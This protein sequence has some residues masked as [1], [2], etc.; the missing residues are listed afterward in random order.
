MIPIKKLSNLSAKELNRLFNR[1][2]EDFASI[3]IEA[4]IP[5]VRDVGKNGEQAVIKYT[6]KFD[7]VDLD[8]VVASSEEIEAGRRNVPDRL[9]DAFLEAKRNIEEFHMLQK[10]GD[11]RHEREGGTLL[12]ARYQPVESAAVY[13]PGGKASYPSSVLMGVIRISRSS[14]PRPQT[15][16][17]PTSS[18][19][20]APCWESPQW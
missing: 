2:G 19:P 9:F 15:E 4:V 11:I 12:G 5:I 3:M 6:K 13:V 20:C 10:R 16:A 14:P 1:L 7:G 8:S 17:L 18:A